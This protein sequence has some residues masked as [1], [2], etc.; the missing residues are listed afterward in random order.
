MDGGGGIV[1]VAVVVTG[2]VRVAVVLVT[3]ITTTT[4]PPLLP[5]PY[6]HHHHHLNPTNAT[7]ITKSAIAKCMLC[8][9]GGMKLVVMGGVVVRL[10]VVVAVGKI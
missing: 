9:E 8:G 7:I 10:V 2:L 3:T 1:V 6:H 4:R 5:I